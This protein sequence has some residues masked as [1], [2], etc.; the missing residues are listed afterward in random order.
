MYGNLSSNGGNQLSQSGGGS[1]GSIYV[2]AMILQI[3]GVLRANGGNAMS[4][5]SGGGGGGG[6]IT[7]VI[8]D[9]YNFLASNLSGTFEVTGGLNAQ[10]SSSASSG[11]I[12]WPP[13]P[14]GWGGLSGAPTPYYQ[15]YSEKFCGSCPVGKY[16]DALSSSGCQDCKCEFASF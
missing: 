5:A 16:S 13:C 9:P 8:I 4:G 1:G 2:S 10:G 15:T 11:V 12:N 6:V 7:M 14:P 3:N